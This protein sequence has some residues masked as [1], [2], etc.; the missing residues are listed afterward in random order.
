MPF[1]LIKGVFTPQIGEPDGDSVRFRANQ[2]EL[3]LQLE[4]RRPNISMSNGTVQLRFEGIDA[5]EKAAIK[6]FSTQAKESMF[7]LIGYSDSQPTPEGYILARMTDD[8]SG[9]PICFVFAGETEQSDGEEIFLDKVLLRDS[10]NYQQM[11]RGYAYPLYYNTLFANLRNELNIALKKAQQEK[12]GYWIDDQT[13]EGVTVTNSAD[14]ATIPPIWPKLWRRLQE[15]LR[16]ADSLE[17]FIDFLEAKNERIDILSLME[18]R[19]LQD[20]VE[21]NGERVRMIVPP[22]YIRVVSQAGGRPRR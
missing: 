14:L 5:I 4:G 8:T 11:L 12:L 22:E 10:V 19:G 18:E 9:R 16:S 20:I 2:R 21:V 6:P 1:I 3:L 7:D 17:Q 13:L 15:Y